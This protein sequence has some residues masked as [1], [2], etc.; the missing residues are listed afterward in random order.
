MD[1]RLKE[2]CEMQY[3]LL[4]KAGQFIIERASNNEIVEVPDELNTP[5]K[6]GLFRSLGAVGA[7]LHTGAENST[8]RMVFAV[9]G[10]LL[11]PVVPDDAETAIQEYFAVRS[12]V[13]FSPMLVFLIEVVLSTHPSEDGPSSEDVDDVARRLIG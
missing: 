11:L 10:K 7:F 3:G 8:I 5:F 9:A 6:E 12:Y 2:Y 13:G 1:A 4:S